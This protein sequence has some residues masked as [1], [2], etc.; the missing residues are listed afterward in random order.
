MQRNNKLQLNKK[1]SERCLLTRNQWEKQ[2][3]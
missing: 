2:W 3:K 1:K